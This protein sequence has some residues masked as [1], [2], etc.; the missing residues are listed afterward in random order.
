MGCISPA[1]PTRPRLTPSP[2]PSP[3]CSGKVAP[4]LIE[5][6]SEYTFVVFGAFCAVMCLYV[7]FFFKETAGVRLEDMAALYKERD[8]EKKPLAA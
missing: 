3:A 8:F 4:L 6:I 7:F 2:F 1:L 5:G